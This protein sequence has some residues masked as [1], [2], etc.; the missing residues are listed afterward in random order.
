VSV[1]LRPA[2]AA[3]FAAFSGSHLGHKLAILLDGKLLAA[4]VIKSRIDGDSIMLSGHFPKEMR[5]L[6]ATINAAQSSPAAPR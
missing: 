4:P 6:A 1:H 3:R 5:R 2:A